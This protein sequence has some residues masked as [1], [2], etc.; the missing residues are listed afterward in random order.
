MVVSM[1]S[2]P[3]LA[4]KSFSKSSLDRHCRMKQIDMAI[5]LDHELRLTRHRSPTM[6]NFEADLSMMVPR[7]Y[8]S[9]LGGKTPKYD[10]PEVAKKKM[11]ENWPRP[12]RDRIPAGR[13]S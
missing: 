1:S 7:P 5:K 12:G 9:I 8:E 11:A 13:G 4:G 10:F 3:N 2:E 6:Q